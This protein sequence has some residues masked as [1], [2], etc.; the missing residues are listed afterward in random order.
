ML[1]LPLHIICI[2]GTLLLVAY[3]DEQALLWVLG[4][5]QRLD[6]RKIMFLH[7]AIAIGLALL[8][9]TGG[10]LYA[11]AATR[12][13]ADPTFIIKMVAVAAL[14]INTYFI[15]K[16]SPLAITHS[17]KELTPQ[18]RLPLFISGAVSGIGWVTALVCGL[19]L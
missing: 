4:K 1:L 15:G 10:L 14:I 13:L 17:F 2:I 6:E 11:R 16:F 18:Q 9:V 7:H 8:L 5:K 12:Y 19:L 3:T